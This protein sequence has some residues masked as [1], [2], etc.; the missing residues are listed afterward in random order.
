MPWQPSL[1]AT[2]RITAR[3]SFEIAIGADAQ[4][5]GCLTVRLTILAISGCLAC[6]SGADEVVPT[7]SGAPAAGT[8]RLEPV[9]TSPASSP[10]ASAAP[11]S[12]APAV[13]PS[14]VRRRSDASEPAFD[15][16]PGCRFQGPE[17]WARG[18]AAW[19]GAC[20]NGFAEGS[21]VIVNVVEGA[22]PERF[23]GQLDRGSP[24]LGVLQTSSGFIAGRWERGSL[25]A[26]LP[27]DIAQRNVLIHAFRAAANAATETSEGFAK[28]ADA[29]ASSFYAKQARQLHDQM[30]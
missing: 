3:A 12:A 27:D 13:A 4:R 28:K 24:R 6:D 2:D 1:Q 5:V 10:R 14:A 15:G 18:R 17:A 20:E 21:G 25:A 26:A 22:E 9:N 11:T 16:E 29:E 30:D 8:A 7:S 23:Y 19:L